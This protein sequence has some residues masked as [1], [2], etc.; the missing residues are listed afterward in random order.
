[1]AE[2]KKNKKNNNHLTKIRSVSPPKSN[3]LSFKP[4]AICV[5]DISETERTASQEGEQV[6]NQDQNAS[7]IRSR[8]R[9]VHFLTMLSRKS[10][11]CTS[12]LIKHE[13][14]HSSSH[15]TAEIFSPA[16]KLSVPQV[17]AS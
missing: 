14:V 4:A 9:K 15:A 6:I 13:S 5:P 7:K 8:G 16:A 17:G 11:N 2:I 10:N 12:E 3:Q 1:M